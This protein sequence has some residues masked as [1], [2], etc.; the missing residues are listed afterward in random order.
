MPVYTTKIWDFSALSHLLNIFDIYKNI[1]TFFNYYNGFSSEK[2]FILE[3][4]GDLYQDLDSLLWLQCQYK[5]FEKKIVNFIQQ[6]TKIG[7]INTL[8]FAEIIEKYNPKKI[9]QFVFLLEKLAN[10]TRNNHLI[11]YIFSRK[12][13]SIHKKIF[14]FQEFL[15]K[16]FTQK[17]NDMEVIFSA[18]L[19]DSARE[20]YYKNSL[21]RQLFDCS[22]EY[23]SQ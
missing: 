3:T 6:S 4:N 9:Q 2:Q 15:K 13:S 18:I 8:T 16:Y 7:N 1:G 21:D 10:T 5:I 12:L 22:L 20:N 19:Q 11:K 23:N 14:L 17:Q